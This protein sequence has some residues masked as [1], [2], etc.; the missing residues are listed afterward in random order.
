MADTSAPAE[1][2]WLRP[3]G[4]PWR[5]EAPPRPLHANPWFAVEESLA[6]A[7]T[8]VEAR[9]FVQ[10]YANLATG[11]VPLHAD[12]T[13]TLVGQ[14]RFPLGRFNWEIPEGGAPHGE[15]PLEGCRRELRE[16]AGLQAT[17]W[18][19]ILVMELSNASSDELA[20][21]Y[22]ATGLT[23]CPTAPEPTEEL[24][25]ARVPFTQALHAAVT[26]RVQDAI[27]VAALLRVHHMAV[28]GELEPALARAV[29]G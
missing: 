5:A 12:G 19:E 17:D 26:G 16:E 4:R 21:V 2:S 9:Y 25:V 23:P 8:G 6:E 15:P 14:W 13:V 3:H 20:H 22:L 18:R 28:T 7:P 11:V 29:L 27:S 10:R 1:L 24:T